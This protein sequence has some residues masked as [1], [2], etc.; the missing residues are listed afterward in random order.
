MRIPFGVAFSPLPST[1]TS[2][3]I[4][5]SSDDTYT[6]DLVIVVA[7]LVCAVVFTFVLAVITAFKNRRTSTLTS[8]DNPPILAT[9]QQI[10]IEIELSP[11]LPVKCGLK[12]SALK[13]LP[14][15]VYEKA[16]DGVEKQAECAICLV[17][18]EEG[19]EIRKLPQCGHEFHI[20]CVD[21]WLRAQPSCPTCRREVVVVPSWMKG[22]QKGEERE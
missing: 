6:P 10:Q 18:F 14:K 7:V 2:A 9:L 1:S 15:M 5:V 20:G 17:E 22:N 4:T 19:D 21:K 12:K 13:A 8:T 3:T 11:L 16:A